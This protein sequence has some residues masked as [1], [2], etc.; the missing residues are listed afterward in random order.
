MIDFADVSMAYTKRSPVALENVSFHID[1]GEFVFVIGASGS[2]KSTV[3]KLISCEEK[4]QEG[5]IVLGGSRLKNIKKRA[6]PYVRRN[7]GMI[8][9]DFRLIDSKTVYENVAFAMEIVG[10]SK[11]KIRRQVPIVLSTVGL[12][13]KIHE[14]PNELSGGEQQRVAIARAIINNPQLLLADEPTGNLDPDT[15]EQIMA[16]LSEINREGTTVV[17]C[18]HDHDL[19]DIM[20]QRVI[21]I[22]D[23]RI[24]RDEQQASYTYC[25]VMPESQLV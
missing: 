8:F 25:E 6:I 22:Q 11:R 21:E 18:T 9:Q 14:K 12:R 1:R 7:I 20:R 24:I 15:S 17:V 23:G 4:F 10:A 3:I 5:E 13:S 16:L 2:G 19:V